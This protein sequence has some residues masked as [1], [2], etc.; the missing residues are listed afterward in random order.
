MTHNTVFVSQITRD[1]K[2]LLFRHLWRRLKNQNICAWRTCMGQLKMGKHQAK[3][4]SQ[5]LF[6][7]K[8]NIFEKIF[9]ILSGVFG[10]NLMTT[11]GQSKKV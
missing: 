3:C 10:Q 9:Q 5:E 8:C 11:W 6:A 1:Y 7:R 2:T 4:S